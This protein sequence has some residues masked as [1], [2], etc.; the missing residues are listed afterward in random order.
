MPPGIGLP[1]QA[2]WAWFYLYNEHI[3]RFLGRRIPHDYGQVP[4][5]L[6][7]LLL[8]IWLLPWAAFLPSALRNAFTMLRQTSRAN[9]DP[10]SLLPVACKDATLTTLLW[11]GII[12]GFF[13]L[14]SRQEYYHLPALPALALLVG[15]FLAA[16]DAHQGR[17]PIQAQHWSAWFLVPLGLIVAFICGYFAIT[18]HTPPAG[19]DL[20]A[21]LNNDPTHYNLSLGHLFD[22]T[23]TAM[24]F[25]RGPLATV[26]VGMLI[27]GPLQ[28]LLR[29]RARSYAANL[30]VTTGMTACLLAAHT[31]LALRFT[32]A[33]S[34]ALC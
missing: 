28:H 30:A 25:F 31:G 2:G 32:G 23:G 4:I 8:A 3:A 22:L 34:R 14:S 16:A 24:G 21:L 1:A 12:L 33:L 27:L 9:A 11:A 26:A 20:Y 19:A 17:A 29:R 6:F 13:T 10:C 7:W 18:A 5:P 15:A